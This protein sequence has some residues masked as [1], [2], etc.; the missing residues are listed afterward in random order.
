MT[1][2]RPTPAH[3]AFGGSSIV[4]RGRIRGVGGGVGSSPHDATAAARIARIKARRMRSRS[5]AAEML[6]VVV[7]GQDH[8][9]GRIELA[10]RL[11]RPGS[12]PAG[13]V[14]RPERE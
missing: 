9:A 4:V 11:V 3:A 10:E 6:L 8:Q 5:E 14:E 1:V 12:R 2:A 7:D 13:V